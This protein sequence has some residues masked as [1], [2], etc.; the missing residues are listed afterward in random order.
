MIQLHVVQHSSIY[1]CLFAFFF[2]STITDVISLSSIYLK[3]YLKTCYTDLE[4]N[5]WRQQS[6]QINT[7]HREVFTSIQ[8][9][10][11]VHPELNIRFDKPVIAPF[12]ISSFIKCSSILFLRPSN[13][14]QT[15]FVA[16]ALSLVYSIIL[17]FSSPRPYMILRILAGHITRI[18]SHFSFTSSKSETVSYDS[19]GWSTCTLTNRKPIA[20]YIQYEFTLPKSEHKL[21]IGLGQKVILCFLDDDKIIKRYFYINSPLSQKGWFTVLV[22]KPQFKSV[23]FGD[24][25]AFKPGNFNLQITGQIFPLQHMIFLVVGLGIIPTLQ[26]L[27]YFLAISSTIRNFTLIYMNSKSNDFDIALSKLENEYYKY[28]KRLS[29]L[30]VVDNLLNINLNKELKKLIPSFQNDM[31][32]IVAGEDKKF[33]ENGR[34]FFVKCSGFPEEYVQVIAP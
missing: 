21:N 9:T 25:L 24:Q 7:I 23:S 11:T 4:N 14:L 12:Q 2:F 33:V 26:Y 17:N 30:F 34:D 13:I 19:N 28:S 1:R 29:V 32:G 5:S 16:M 27:K 8:P 18:L 20:S 31:I 3:R 22:T 10:D 6:I 15:L